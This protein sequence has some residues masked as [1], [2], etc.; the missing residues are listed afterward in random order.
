MEGEQRGEKPRGFSAPAAAWGTF[1]SCS[2][3]QETSQRECVPGQHSPAGPHPGFSRD[4][5]QLKAT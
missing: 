3:S 1:P 5:E 2:E 4:H